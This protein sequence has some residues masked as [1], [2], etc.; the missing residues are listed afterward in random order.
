MR[1][2]H[3]TASLRPK[4]F[5]SPFPYCKAEFELKSTS[6]TSNGSKTQEARMRDSLQ[7]LNILAISCDSS[8]AATNI[9]IIRGCDEEKKG[10]ALIPNCRVVQKIKCQAQAQRCS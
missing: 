3:S 6:I 2:Y 4:P 1:W 9:K 10:K 8:N 7:W 5:L